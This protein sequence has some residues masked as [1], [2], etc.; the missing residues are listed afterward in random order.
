MSTRTVCLLAAGFAA[1]S[2]FGGAAGLAGAGEG[3][4]T[5]DSLLR[6]MADRDALA[7]LPQPAYT[8]RQFS[9]YERK[10]VS[11]DDAKGW[12]ANHDWSHFLREETNGG[13]KEWV[14]MDAQGPGCVVR[15]WSGGPK[16][17]SINSG[18][19]VVP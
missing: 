5:F 4:I 9:S 1:A 17:R 13:R 11:P 7:R 16:P 15:M 3:A 8:C 19:S 6:E 10:S 12:F 2:L 18:V 14:M